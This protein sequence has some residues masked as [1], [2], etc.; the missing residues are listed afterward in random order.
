MIPYFQFTT[1]PLGPVTVQVWGLM[2]ALGILAATWVA[3]KMARARGQDPKIIWDLS[4]WVIVGAFIMARV[5]MVI[6]EPGYYFADPIEFFRIW[7]GGFS[8]MG[9]FLG[10]TIAG[11]WF[12]RRKHV[13]V[14]AYTDTAI[15][16]LPV[17]LFIGRI[18]CFLI[19]D[20]PGTLTD[21]ALGVKYPDGVRH[22]HG[23]YDSIN[24]LVLF[25]LF[26][27]LARRGAKTGTYIVVFL[28]WYGVVRF[29]LDFFRA[30]NG[31]IVDTRYFSL[32]PAQYAAIVMVA[33]GVWLWRK[34]LER[35]L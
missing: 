18:G 12:L 15:F 33:G 25:L 1:I 29:F 22:D 2:V 31:P 24:G 11:I 16:G 35:S 26:L 6:Y 23:L 8:I 17:G 30:T 9:G 34:K 27:L 21:F 13:D 14:H 7:H 32:T 28:I 3:G 4:V 10:A 5:F 19:H 20:H